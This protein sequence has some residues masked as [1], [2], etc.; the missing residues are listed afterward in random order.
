MRRVSIA[1][2]MSFIVVCAVAIAAM[3]YANEAWSVGMVSLAAFALVWSLLC[4]AYRRAAKRA[5]WVGFAVFGWIYFGLALAPHVSDGFA[6][7]LP[8]SR[9]LGLAYAKLHPDRSNGVVN[10]TASNFLFTAQ[11][12]GSTTPGSPSAV[13]IMSGPANWAV[14]PT[15]N[16]VN[17]TFTLAWVGDDSQHFARIGHALIT[18]AVGVVGGLAVVWLYRTN[19]SD[20]PERP[21][22]SSA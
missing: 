16:P 17:G 8:T 2:V 20:T 21:S 18:L 3:R 19:R 15:P 1:A 9:G 5:F 10:L 12:T 14:T 4:I 11:S 6:P 13:Q 22:T 7:H